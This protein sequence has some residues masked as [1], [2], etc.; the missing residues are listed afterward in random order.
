MCANNLPRWGMVGTA[1]CLTVVCS[2]GWPRFGLAQDGGVIEFDEAEVFF[3]FNATDL[4]LGIHIFFDAEAWQAVQVRGPGGTIFE[5]NNGGGLQQIGSTEVF[6]ESAEPPLDE[7]N[8]QPAIDAFLARFPAG[9][10]VFEGTTIGGA[11]LAGTAELSHDL[12]AAPGLV[13]PDPDASENVADPL[14]TVI[15]WR[16]TSGA[17]DPTIVRYHVVVEFEE[18]E[19]ERAFVFGLDVPAPPGA[20]THSV[21]VPSEF[22]E[23][24]AGLQGTFKAEV[25]A[26]A[27]GGNATIS[28]HEF[29]V[30]TEIVFGDCNGDGVYNGLD[31]INAG[32]E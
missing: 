4:D 21:T 18:E 19:T 11:T 28:E 5:V 31:L 6:T 25:V 14:D 12:P 23:N 30:D 7:Q 16:D 20:V 2:L 29:E 15:E 22:F 10:Y 27:A 1:L 3:E 24:L 17:G 32:C 9:E 13:F 8:L 26:M